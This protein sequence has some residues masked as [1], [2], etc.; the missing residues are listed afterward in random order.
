MFD[1]ASEDHRPRPTAADDIGA[2]AFVRND[3]HARTL[4]DADGV[5][6]LHGGPPAGTT[7]RRSWPHPLP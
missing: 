1:P 7:Q 6:A 3:L 5:T 2:I 4:V